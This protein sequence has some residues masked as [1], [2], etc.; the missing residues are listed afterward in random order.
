MTDLCVSSFWT[1][2]LVGGLLTG[3]VLD[4]LLIARRRR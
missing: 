4:L 3:M 2:V 1:G